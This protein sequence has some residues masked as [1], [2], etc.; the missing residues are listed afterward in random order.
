MTIGHRIRRYGGVSDASLV[1]LRNI[2]P[3]S[4][5]M[6]RIQSDLEA[7]YPLPSRAVES[8]E[9]QEQFDAAFGALT[10]YGPGPRMIAIFNRAVEGLDPDIFSTFL[11]RTVHIKLLDGFAD[12][13][14]R[15]WEPLVQQ[16]S[17]SDFENN[18]SVRF[19][20][21]DDLVKRVFY[22]SPT[23]MEEL[24][25]FTMPTWRG[26]LYS[27]GFEIPFETT[28]IEDLAA[29]IQSIY[30]RGIAANR[31]LEKFVLVTSTQS[32]PLITVDDTSQNLFA[33]SHTG[34]TDNDLNASV[35]A[36]SYA[37]L[38]AI[39][40][41]AAAQTVDGEVADVE[42]ANIVVK[43]GSE[44][45]LRAMEVLSRA[46]PN[47]PD[48]TNTGDVKVLGMEVPFRIIA[49]PVLNAN[50]WA[51][52]VNISSAPGMA[53]ELG[54]LDGNDTPELVDIDQ[55]ASTYFRTTGKNRWM[56]KLGFGGTWRD[57]RGV[58]RGSPT[59]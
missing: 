21:P 44:N 13:A 35:T 19:E 55:T 33:D 12:P 6:A 57:F 48:T 46:L 52:T 39:F 30:Q 28:R 32:N 50:F 7:A 15:N 58:Y 37:Q 56:V 43:K 36:F 18:E 31:T 27:T 2:D 34:G 59:T 53:F 17:F 4:P 38:E 40:K 25:E 29:R 8:P 24:E 9:Q 45:H 14:Y 23:K 51:V 1:D 41:L 42:L 22:D 26:A 11:R 20:N 54:F 47:A 3:K 49:S 10:E 16:V 5:E